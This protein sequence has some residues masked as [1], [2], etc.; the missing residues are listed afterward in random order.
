MDSQ[1]EAYTRQG[2][3]SINQVYTPMITSLENDVAS[4]FGNFDNSI[5]LDSL[6]G[7]ESSRAKAVS[8]LSQ[9]IQAKRTEIENNEIQK[10]YDYL[11][12]LTN[13]QNQSFQNMLNA[14]KLNQSNLSLSNDYLADSFSSGNKNQSS[15]NN[16]V[17]LS[18]LTN[19]LA[20]LAKFV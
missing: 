10:Q 20:T 13:Y 7:I 6:K 14:S 16:S 5:F 3:D 15:N 8:A 4:R 2:I 11:N 17:N 19:Y 1:V 12:F 18:Q 9:D